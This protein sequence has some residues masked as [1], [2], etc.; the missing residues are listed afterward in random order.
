MQLL[1]GLKF[2][3]L[4]HSKYL[5]KTPDFSKLPNLEK[6]ILKDCPSLFEVH[7]SIG[8]LNNLLLLNLKDCTCLGNLP[9]VIYKLKS[10]QT[11]ILSGCSNIDKLEE[12]IGQMESLTTLFADNTRLKQVPFAI[13][14]SKRIGY[15]SLCGYKGLAR[16]VFPSL[17]WSLMSHT[18]G[19]L[20]CFQPFGIM[21]TSIVSMDIQDTNL[22][23]LS[24]FREFSKLRS[25]SVQCDSDFQLTQEQ[26]IVLHELCNVNF[27]GSEN[28]YLSPIS[29]NSMVSYLIG[30]GSY[31]Q[32]FTMLSNR[33]SEVLLS[34]FLLST[35]L[36]LFIFTAHEIFFPHKIMYL[37]T[38]HIMGL[39]ACLFILHFAC[40]NLLCTISVAHFWSLKIHSVSIVYQFFMA[41]QFYNVFSL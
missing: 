23:N 34:L 4:S 3:N 13:V 25:V 38:Q 19:V 7:H 15:V 12:A 14:R 11:L 37:F 27:S 17:I 28:A 16:N 21:P 5:S 2:L 26:R 24:N 8:D 29:E 35:L 36:F 32:V 20:S 6:L 41:Y 40:D 9:M 22:V 31:K 10:L 1:E 30:M 18:R 39:R 33:I